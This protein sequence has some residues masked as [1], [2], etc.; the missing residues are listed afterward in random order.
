MKQKTGYSLIRDPRKNKGTA[1]TLEE[2]KKY[3]L[4]GLLPAQV[5]TIETQMLRVNGQLDLIDL[6]INKYSYLINLLETNE[7]L[8]FNL[9]INDPAKYLPLVYTPTVGEACE[10]FGHIARRVRGL[11]ISIEQKDHIKE[12][13]RN[14]PE[15]DIRFTVVTDG[16]RILGLGDLGI[17]GLG[18]PIGKLALYTGCAGVP[19]QYT[20]PIVLDAGTNNEKYLNDPL[21]PGLKYK[22]IIGKKYDDFIEAFVV[23]IN[24]VFPKICIQWE[25]F[26]GVDA[27]RILSK[28]REKVCTYNDDIQGTAAIATAGFISI[29]RLSGKPFSELKFLFLGA[30][31]AAFGIADLLVQKF[32]KDGLS[33]K[34]ALE[35][36]WMFDVNGLLV[37]SRTDL[38]GYQKPFAHKGDFT[39]DFAEAV[40]QI[41]PTAIVGVSTV[42]GAFNQKVIENMSKVNER[43][44]IFPYSNPTSHSECTAEQAYTWSKGKAIF[45]SGSP[46]APVNFNGKTFTPGQGNNV[47][48]FPA[49]G[50][51]IFATE[52]KRVTDEM[53]ITAAEAVAEQVSEKD[54]ENG[55]IYPSVNDIMKVSLNVAV[56]VAEEIFKNGLSGVKRPNDIRAFIKKKM[57]IPVYS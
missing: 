24:E 5:E 48:I 21:Y 29:S 33:R 52:A 28:F 14:W 15:K 37:H 6:P 42:G 57:Y 25:D 35:H 17:C 53:F 50:L 22:R 40:L 31:A 39:K 11:F 1:F 44:I 4:E 9:I 2:R 3:G 10:K 41:K 49:M 38:S 27:I 30:G 56:K 47:F 7:T 51:A 20:L 54:F 16:G 23:A 12:I 19:S 13:L 8:F 36:I 34:D 32:Q 26:K 46:F 45:A 43:P 18:I 55:L